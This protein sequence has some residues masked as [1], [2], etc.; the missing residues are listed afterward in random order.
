MTA[1]RP[2]VLWIA[3]WYPPDY[4]GG[5]EWTAHEFNRFLIASRGVRVIVASA[6]VPAG[7]FEGVEI[8]SVIDPPGLRRLVGRASVICTQLDHTGLAAHLATVCRKPIVYFMH[9]TLRLACPYRPDN[10][11]PQHVVYNA[12]WVRDELAF[13]MTSVVARPPVDW[14]RFRVETT[15][16]CVTL[17]NVRADKGSAVFF[18]CARRM[19]GRRFLGSMGFLPPSSEPPAL[20]NVEC[21]PFVRDARQIY[22]RTRVLLMPSA[23][24][25]WG[26]TAVEAMA[27][28]I[29]VIA[30]PT[31][32][33]RESLGPAGIFCDRDR[34]EDWV[35]A[36]ERL[37]DPTAYA[38]ASD[39]AWRR[40]RELDPADDLERVGKL[41]DRCL[42]YG[43]V[44]PLS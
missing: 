18:E 25:S 35:A 43:A 40:A 30:H 44:P 13:P 9:S 12:E 17:V 1:S 20:P 2:L 8:R 6:R 42:K 15:R 31:P 11:A 16:E 24:E 39:A 32:G 4:G 27:S 37:D 19:P 7:K 10:P 14:R 33:L 26:R 3:P 28:G 36:I 23:Y 29:P 34:V 38:A 5:A 22:A 41:V 21:V